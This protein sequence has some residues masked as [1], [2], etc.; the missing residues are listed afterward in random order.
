MLET[1]MWK[2]LYTELRNSRHISISW[3]FLYLPCPEAFEEPGAGTVGSPPPGA[4]SVDS[5]DPLD[6]VEPLP[7]PLPEPLWPTSVSPDPEQKYRNSVC[8]F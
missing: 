3:L 1:F 2:T 6:P 8:N 4:V 7:E 5:L